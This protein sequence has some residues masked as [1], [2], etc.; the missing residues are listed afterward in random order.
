MFF[1]QLNAAETQNPLKKAIPMSKC[2]FFNNKFVGI[3]RRH[4]CD[5]HMA[6]NSKKNPMNLIYAIFYK[7]HVRTTLDL[8]NS[9]EMHI[10]AQLKKILH[11]NIC[12]YM[13]FLYE[14]F[15]IHITNMFQHISR[16]LIT[17]DL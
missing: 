9:Q 15:V 7:F 5:L 10:K 11:M 12:H 1:L 17:K 16:S 6:F 13:V 4:S 14:I 2:R 8:R 3:Y